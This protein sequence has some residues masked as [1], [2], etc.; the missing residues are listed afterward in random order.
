MAAVINIYERIRSFRC[1]VV[2]C[3]YVVVLLTTCASRARAS[4]TTT[5]ATAG[6]CGSPN[7]ARNLFCPKPG[8][9]WQIQFV[10]R[11]QVSAGIPMYDIDLF[12]TPK[13]T[14][15]SLKKSK[16]FVVCYFSAG[17]REDW[18]PDANKFPAKTVG[19][20]LPDWDGER[21]LDIR[22]TLVRQVLAAR[23]D[24]AVRKGCHAVDPD[25]VDAFTN[26]SGFQL[27]AADQL[28]FNRWIARSAHSRGLSVGLKNDLRQ[29]AALVN[30]FDF[31]IN[32]QCNAYTECYYLDPFIKKGKAVF[33]IEY[34]ERTSQA[35]QL[36]KRICPT[37][38]KKKFSTIIKS[39]D[40]NA[41]RY[42]C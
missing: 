13:T 42:S 22:S 7:A 38:T 34:V 16:H 25:N 23:L 41:W 4:P 5:R 19:K 31:A 32:E 37:M 8:L 18:R 24:L 21:W 35:A 3:S 14:I 10:G 27:T 12:D 6:G 17:T 9:K 11:L 28:D 29:V 26:D 40:L 1:F 2:T 39:N 33:N 20:P 15:A 30:D 36:A